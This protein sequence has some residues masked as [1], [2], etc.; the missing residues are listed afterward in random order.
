MLHE[1]LSKIIQ[2]NRENH[3][4]SNCFFIVSEEQKL[5]ALSASTSQSKFRNDDVK[6]HM[7]S[8]VV[9]KGKHFPI[10]FTLSLDVRDAIVNNLRISIYF[11]KCRWPTTNEESEPAKMQQ[12]FMA[13]KLETA[14]NKI[15]RMG[16][17]DLVLPRQ[18]LMFVDMRIV[19]PRFT[20]FVPLSGASWKL[21]LSVR[22]KDKNSDALVLFLELSLL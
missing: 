18:H 19:T 1:K 5:R 3:D 17:S 10:D 14:R 20:V 7:R 8:V 2:S 12:K 15:D 21:F 11:V 13:W 22:D 4:L 9:V 6:H 16:G